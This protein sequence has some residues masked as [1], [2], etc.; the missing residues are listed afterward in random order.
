[1]NLFLI[2]ILFFFEVAI[3]AAVTWVGSLLL[4]HYPDPG[5]GGGIALF[6]LNVTLF[7]LIMIISIAILIKNNR[8]KS[9]VII[10]IFLSF[11]LPLIFFLVF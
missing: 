9:D 3:I 6:I 5:Y 7:I 1:M 2:P 10:F 8:P 4:G 11:L